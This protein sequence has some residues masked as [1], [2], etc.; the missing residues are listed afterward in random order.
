[1]QQSPITRYQIAGTSFLNQTKYQQCSR[2]LRNENGTLNSHSILTE[3]L[4]R[5]KDKDI[6]NDSM[7]EKQMGKKQKLAVPHTAVV[8]GY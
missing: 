4:K 7:Q 5:S 6:W 3:L 2:D 1:M 8:S